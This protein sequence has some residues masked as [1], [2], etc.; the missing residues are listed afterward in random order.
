MRFDVCLKNLLLAFGNARGEVKVW[1]ITSKEEYILSPPCNSFVRTVSFSP[2]GKYIVAACDD[3][4][5]YIW[6]AIATK[7]KSVSC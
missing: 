5:I 7:D 1:Q 3:A 2:D 6:D 4:T